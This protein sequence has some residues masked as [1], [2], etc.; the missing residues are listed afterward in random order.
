MYFSFYLSLF[1]CLVWVPFSSFLLCLFFVPFTYLPIYSP[2]YLA[3][4]ILFLLICH[5]S[6]FLSFFL[7]S[8]DIWTIVKADENKLQVWN[9]WTKLSF[10]VLSTFSSISFR[11]PHSVRK[12]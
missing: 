7:S 4:L 2:I 9:M 3:S 11:G 1:L 5:S 10:N 12:T 6:F 8:K